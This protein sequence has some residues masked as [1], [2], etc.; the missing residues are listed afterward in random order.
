MWDRE[1]ILAGSLPQADLN[2]RNQLSRAL[3]GGKGFL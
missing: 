1:A 3:I 2:F